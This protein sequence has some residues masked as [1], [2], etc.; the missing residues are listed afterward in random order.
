MPSIALACLGCNSANLGMR[1][2]RGQA[3]VGK[4]GR[5]LI[6]NKHLACLLEYSLETGALGMPNP[7]FFLTILLQCQQQ[8]NLHV[9]C[10]PSLEVQ[11][12]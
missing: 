9:Q 10:H 7:A 5:Q 6:M 2:T 11:A 4:C 3:H 8:L 12:S 1:L